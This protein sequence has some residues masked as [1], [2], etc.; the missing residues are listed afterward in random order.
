M[1][2]RR[3]L[4]NRQCICLDSIFFTYHFAW[5]VWS[6]CC[7]WWDIPWV[8]FNTPSINIESWNAAGL[9]GDGKK[10]WQLCFYAIV[11]SIWDARNK[12]VFQNASVC[13]ESSMIEL[14]SRCKGWLPIMQKWWQHFMQISDFLIWL[15]CCNVWLGQILMLLL[16]FLLLSGLYFI[17]VFWG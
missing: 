7:K 9:R 6:Y 10:A 8:L 14:M 12:V 15:Q 1:F 4:I 5:R 11:W 17:S 2:G 16:V 3:D 13:W